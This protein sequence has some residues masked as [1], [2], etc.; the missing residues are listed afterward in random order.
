MN[1]RQHS[2]KNLRKENFTFSFVF[3]FVKSLFSEMKWLLVIASVLLINVSV[4]AADSTKIRKKFLVVGAS[5]LAYKGS[6]QESYARWTPGFQVGIKFE[7]RKLVNGMLSATFGK[8]IGENRNYQKPSKFG[9][10]IQP[11]SKFQT[12]FFSLQYEAQV[13]LLTYHGFRIFAS[14]GIG[15]FRFTPQD[16]DGN[17]LFEKDRTRNKGESFSKNAIQFP[18]QIGFQYWF[19][20]Q[21]GFGFQAGWFNTLTKF[22][23]NMSDLSTNEIS[24]NVAAFRFQFFYHLEQTTRQNTLPQRVKN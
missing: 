10:E 1:S 14:Q 11:V 9:D 24:D 17:S 6:L 20:N 18:T 4:N 12:T 21:M 16:W 15:L 3:P 23:D 22:I 7:K 13:L 8:L 5:A 2:G 19:P